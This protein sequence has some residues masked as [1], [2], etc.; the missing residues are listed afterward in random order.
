MGSESMVSEDEAQSEYD[1]HEVRGPDPVARWLLLAVIGV[2]VL[3]VAGMFSAVLFGVLA[4]PKAPRTAAERDLVL[5][6]QQVQS[7]TANTRTWAQYIDVLVT[8]GQLSKARE[9]IGLALP[10]AKADKSF[11]LAEQ[12]RL[13]LVEKDY[14]DAVHSA[15]EAVAQAE[16]EYQAQAKANA[17][18]QIT[19]GAQLPS[20]W[21]LALLTKARALTSSGDNANAVKAYNS[22]LE[23]NK[24]DADIIVRRGDAK[25]ALGDTAGAGTDYR[26]ALKFIPDF[27]PALD[28]LDR[29]GADT[30]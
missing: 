7:G 9:S 2:I 3:W 18:R 19:A 26:T 20:S 22:Y 23:K 8:A 12:A 27:K 29:I 24:T 30:K 1:Y 4:P 14:P 21:D 13:Y 6:R 28:G 15:D 11:I 5:L 16:A 17:A 25:A 10:Q